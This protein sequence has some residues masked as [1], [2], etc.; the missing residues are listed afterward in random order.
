MSDNTCMRCGACCAYFR[1]SFYWAEADDGGGCVPAQ[2]T[3]PLSPFLRCMAGT[4]SRKP[5]CT[6]L[7]GKIGECVSCS[8]YIN[9]PSPCREFVQSGVNGQITDACNR[10]RAHY[11]LPPLAKTTADQSGK[12]NK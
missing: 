4:N 3:E 8:I 2:L 6:A 12:R 7:M 10:A 9:R 1:V 11:G 5:R